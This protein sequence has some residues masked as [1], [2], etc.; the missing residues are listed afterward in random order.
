[1]R[2][3][4]NSKLVK[5][6]LNI[7]LVDDDDAIE[8]A[9]RFAIMRQAPS[10]HLYVA[11]NGRTGLEMLRGIPGVEEVPNE[12][13]VVLLDCHMPIMDGLQFLHELRGDEHLRRTP[14]L[15]LTNSQ[16]ES[17]RDT[18]YEL[19]IAGFICKPATM[20]GFTDTVAR[21]EEFLQIVELPG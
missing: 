6:Q 18:A 14:V 10:H 1:M 4:S 19:G 20:K 16:D 13:R 8:A 12:N 17:D 9:I 5:K 15:M 21:M 7:L 3:G 2:A 11:K